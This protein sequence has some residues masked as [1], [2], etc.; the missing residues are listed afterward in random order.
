M[1]NHIVSYHIASL[2]IF[3][4]LIT[5]TISRRLTKGRTNRILFWIILMSFTAAFTDFLNYVV[6][7][8]YPLKNWQVIWVDVCNYL[9]FLSRHSLNM[10]CIFFIYSTTHTWFRISAPWKIVVLL[11]PY[12]TVVAMYTA[13][14]WVRNLYFVTPELGY[15]RGDDIYIPTLL[16]MSYMLFGIY[17]LI[18]DK[19]FLNLSEWLSMSSIY[20]FNI[21]G[22]I[23]QLFFESLIIESY[24]TAISILFL[25]LYV[26]KPEK[27]L[28]LNTGL[29][30][31]F[32]FRDALKKIELTGEN[33][34]I[35]IVCIEN[36]DDLSKLMGE[37]NYTEYIHIIAQTIQSYARKEK[38]SYEF[39]YEEPGM[40]YIL[41]DDAA[42]NPIQAMPEIRDRVRKNTSE[43]S[44]TGMRVVVKSVFINFP[45]EA[46]SADDV[47][48]LG[49]RF[50]RY[51]NTKTLYHAPQISG[52]RNYQIEK[53]FDVIYKRAVESNG[54]EMIYAPIWSEHEQKNVFAEATFKIK[55]PEFGEI[56]E[57]TAR[58]TAKVRGAISVLEEYILEQAFSYVGSGAM[59]KAGFKY[60][61]IK[62][63]AA[64]GMQINLTDQIWNLR[65][66][67]DVHPEQIC[68]AFTETSDKQ[69]SA[70]LKENI[71]K[72]SLQ[73]YRLALDDY[74]NGYLNTH[75]LSELK[76][77]SVR[78]DKRFIEDMHERGGEVTLRGMITILQ[79][80]GLSVVVPGIDDEETKK[81][82]LYMGC[83]LMMGR[84]FV[85]EQP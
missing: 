55:D 69:Y 10:L 44:Y 79:N 3:L 13:N 5:A 61:V 29:P 62:L 53:Q 60:T 81:R 74:G 48:D 31:F 11:I 7:Q 63:S 71:I 8:G 12:L 32:A 65:S 78:L 58:E 33:V 64:L 37:G 21:L 24:F 36:A 72:L 46:A 57:E 85:E 34:K 1:A 6:V 52:Q 19:K 14:F 41:T 22:I 67:Y 17:L 39:Y 18:V 49:Q 77:N 35:L 66:R 28:D 84:L 70:G 15:Q 47:I 43:D 20:V 76:I 40:I 38:V 27:Q 51:S 59:A 25:V 50:I 42:F 54:I 83:D 9:Y 16:V 4:I 56:D 30:G 45:K 82:L 80:L 75:L 23:I 2:P 73:G 68:F 26:Q